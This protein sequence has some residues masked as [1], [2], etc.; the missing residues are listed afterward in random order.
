MHCS[1]DRCLL[2]GEDGAGEALEE[3]GTPEGE[4]GSALIGPQG[5]PP[6][7]YISVLRRGLYVLPF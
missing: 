3:R 6:G 7:L 5:P 1:G 2:Q 4:G